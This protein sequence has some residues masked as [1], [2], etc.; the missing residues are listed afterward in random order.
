MN[1]PIKYAGGKSYI[2]KKI[3]ALMPPHTNFVEPYG[4]SLAVMLAHDPEGHSEIV[5]DLD[6][7][8]QNF[9]RV[10]QDTRKFAK[11]KRAVEAI[12]FSQPHWER[13]F[14]RIDDKT[15]AGAINFF[16]TCRQSMSGRKTDFAPIT[17]TRLRRGMNEQASAWIN[18][19]DGLAEV[20]ARLRRV[21]ILCQDGLKVI[22]DYDGEDTVQYIDTPYLP[23]TRTALKVYGK[24]EM[25]YEQ[26][27]E[28]LKV[29]KKCKSKILLSG[30]NSPLY[31][32]ELVDWRFVQWE[33]PNNSATGK[34][35][36]RR[37]EY[38]WFNFGKR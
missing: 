38:L 14:K 35:K 23:E 2:A 4:G 34:T 37:H 21:V 9:W 11:F 16:V 20:H 5:N 10:L 30:Y 36:Q 3:V 13:A 24:F 17:K 32:K 26:H 12:P 18:S 31:Q 25:T 29:L 27:V 19:V 1:S 33:L 15:V 8:L 7:E 6:S 28:M 22:Q